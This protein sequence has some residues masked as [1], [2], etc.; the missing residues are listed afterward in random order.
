[1]DIKVDDLEILMILQGLETLQDQ[2]KEYEELVYEEELDFLMD[3]NKIRNLH[4]R[5]L[6]KAQNGGF[7]EKE[8]SLL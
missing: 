5:L 4:N 8:K 7:I 6:I 2:A 1:M 3:L